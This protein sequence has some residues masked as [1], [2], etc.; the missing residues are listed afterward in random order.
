VTIGRLLSLSVL[1]ACSI[2]AQDA[3]KLSHV[4]RASGDA[5]VTAKPDRA[6]VTIGVLSQAP[7][8]QAASAQNATQT[9][10]VVDAVKQA[11]S[12]NGQ[13]KTTG[14]SISPDYQY[15]KD[16]NASKVVG[17][18]ASNTVLATVDDL[19]LV[20]KIIDTATHAGANNI[21]GIAFTLRN[22]E[23]VR[24]QALAEAAAKAR[25]SAEAIAKALNLQVL[26]VLAAEAT[27]APIVRPLFAQ[28]RATAQMEAATP[29]PIETG[30]LDIHASV[31]VTLQVQ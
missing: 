23:A 22:D 13:L 30:T 29:T 28:A 15:S 5:T 4:V 1:V 12:G 17:Y 25:A 3:A 27:E 21:N 6:Q 8:A 16:G 19:S 24:A 7:T 26:G 2:P 10:A 9:T 20:G 31:V 11:L 18:H 14:Y